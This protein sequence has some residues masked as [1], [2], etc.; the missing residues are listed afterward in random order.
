MRNADTKCE[1]PILSGGQ[2]SLSVDA[3]EVGQ[4]TPP[5]GLNLDAGRRSGS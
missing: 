1:K 4:R 3:L 5:V 2:G